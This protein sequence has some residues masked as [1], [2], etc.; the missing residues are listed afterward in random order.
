M[1]KFL[2]LIGILF[3]IFCGF[4]IYDNYF[5]DKIPVL[6]IEEEVV[7]VNEL[8]IYGTHLNISGKY[9]FSD[10]AE[11]VLYNGNFISYD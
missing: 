11:L 5:V 2:L 1:K 6:E 8:Y 10:N 9:N 7:D 4:I 3:L